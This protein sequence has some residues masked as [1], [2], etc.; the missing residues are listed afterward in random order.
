MKWDQV[1][2]VGHGISTAL[3]DIYFFGL[4]CLEKSS[5]SCWLKPAHVPKKKT[6]GMS[7]NLQAYSTRYSNNILI[8][9]GLI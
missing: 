8:T 3:Q 7:L 5:L 4:K 9:D 6:N 1:G 2:Q